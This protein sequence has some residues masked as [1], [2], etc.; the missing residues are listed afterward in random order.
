MCV[1]V[2]V[3]GGCALARSLTSLPTRGWQS[4]HR[5]ESAT[6]ALVAITRSLVRRDAVSRGVALGVT[7]VRARARAC[8]RPPPVTSSQRAGCRGAVE[9]E[10]SGHTG[11]RVHARAARCRC[12]RGLAVTLCTAKRQAHGRGEAAEAKAQAAKVMHSRCPVRMS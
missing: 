12:A 9:L 11:A 10:T 1:T 3:R 7:T 6:A 2:V 4:D 8:M 5:F